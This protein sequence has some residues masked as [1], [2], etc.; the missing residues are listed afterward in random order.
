MYEIKKYNLTHNEL[1][2]EH[3]FGLS[4]YITKLQ[5]II[6]YDNVYRSFKI[7]VKLFLTYT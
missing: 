6:I 5:D 3:I 4:F 1:F 7:V 2:L